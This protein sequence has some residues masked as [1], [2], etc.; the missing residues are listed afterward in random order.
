MDLNGA[1]QLLLEWVCARGGSFT[2]EEL[3]SLIAVLEE[4][5]L[6]PGTTT[7]DEARQAIGLS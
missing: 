4:H 7:L 5:F 2:E 6:S 1:K 3:D